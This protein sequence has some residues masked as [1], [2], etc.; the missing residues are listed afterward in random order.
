MNY[1]EEEQSKYITPLAELDAL[2]E[3]I[4]HGIE[5]M[6]TDRQQLEVE[7]RYRE[8]LGEVVDLDDEDDE[9]SIQHQEMVRKHLEEQ[10]K[11]ARKDDVVIIK[12]SE[13]QKKKIQEEMTV[14]IVRPVPDSIYNLT[15]DQLSSSAEEKLLRT[16]L[17]KIRK[18]YFNQAEYMAA[19]KVILE[20]SVYSALHDY[21]WMSEQ[22]ALEALRKGEI[23]FSYCS[24]P[25][26]YLDYKTKVTDPDTLRGIATGDIE[27]IDKSERPKQKKRKQNPN[28]EPVHMSVTPISKAEE[29]YYLQAHRNGF[30]TPISGIIKS[31]STIYNRFSF[32]NNKDTNE[33]LHGL[34]D[35]DGNAQTFDWLQDNAG[36]KYYDMIHNNTRTISKLVSELNEENN[37]S[38]NK[39]LSSTLSD[40][41]RC[42]NTESG[43]IEDYRYINNDVSKGVK[44]NQKVIELENNILNAIRL[45]NN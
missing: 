25:E 31:K 37:H 6:M 5:P 10:K 16:K 7:M 34:V 18:C 32:Y 35:K 2:V 8:R 23:K 26:F 30:Y 29:E 15:D 40:F 14:S 9:L 28:L 13:E 33:S 1:T 27:V 43:K 39:S 19:M 38:L 12:L 36:A 17:S 44:P 45:S 4:L 20:A 22:E 21:P 41:I 42:L 11:K 24:I 3:Q